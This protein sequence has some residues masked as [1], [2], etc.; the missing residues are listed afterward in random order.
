MMPYHSL[1]LPNSLKDIPLL[2]CVG[3]EYSCRGRSFNL[4]IRVLGFVKSIFT[5]LNFADFGLLSLATWLAS[6]TP[7]TYVQL[8]EEVPAWSFPLSLTGL[9]ASMSVNAL[10][11]G[12]IVFRIFKVFQQVKPT[13]EQQTL[14]ATGGRKLYSIISVIIESGMILFSI[15]LARFVVTVVQTDDADYAYQIIV[16]VHEILTV[17]I[18]SVMSTP[19][20]LLISCWLQGHNTYNHPCAGVNGIVL[21]RRDIDVRSYRDLAFPSRA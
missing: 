21:P 18:R 12:L 13:S 9:G 2:D 10:V 4:S 1:Y 19:Y 7:K 3:S 5:H 11:T 16:C 14:G 15:Q 8:D 17:I 6:I 20:F